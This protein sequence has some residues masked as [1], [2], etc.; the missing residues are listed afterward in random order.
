DAPAGERSRDPA[1][2]RHWPGGR[3]ARTRRRRVAGHA[4]RLRRFQRPRMAGGPAKSR[5]RCLWQC[6][7]LRGGFPMSRITFLVLVVTLFVAV[8]DRADLRSG[9]TRDDV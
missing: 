3:C 6:E 1:N 2:R 7:I 4:A 8:T 5:R 9:A